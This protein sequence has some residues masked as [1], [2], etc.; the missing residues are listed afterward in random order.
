MRVSDILMSNTYLNGI[1][2]NKNRMNQLN[3]QIAGQ[4]KIMKPS[5]SPTGTAKLIRLESKIAANDVYLNNIESS[6]GF[7]NETLRG[8][9]T[10]ERE[11]TNVLVKLVEVDNPINRQNLDHYANQLDNALN[12]ILNAANISFDGKYLFAGTSFSQKPFELSGGGSEVS[13]NASDISGE[14]KV[15]ISDGSNLK[16]NIT[17]EELFGTISSAGTAKDIFNT[18]IN[19]RDTLKNGGYPDDADVQTVKEFHDKLLNK[20]SEAGLYYNTLDNT[21]ALLENQ[22]IEL[23][24][25]ISAEKDLDVAKA[26]IELQNY[27][28]LLQVSYKMSAMI[29]PKSLLDY[30]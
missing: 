24:T 19:I 2:E 1:A 11:I 25:M 10:I 28:Y 18:I 27:D 3:Q 16:I 4:T 21:K 14:L 17:G 20:M 26:I 12:G 6:F 23:Q 29:L 22:K 9:E 30:L 13:S 8:M 7:V 5:D 15:K